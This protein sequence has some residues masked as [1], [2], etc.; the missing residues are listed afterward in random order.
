VDRRIAAVVEQAV[1][2]FEEAGAA[3]EQVDLTFDH[4]QR[5]LS[6]LSC[7]LILPLDIEGLEGLTAQGI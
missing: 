4:D 1:R 7:R 5:E 3:V 6:D 2:A